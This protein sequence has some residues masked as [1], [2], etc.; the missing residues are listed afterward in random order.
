MRYQ[1]RQVHARIGVGFEPVAEIAH[2][3]AAVLDEQ[4]RVADDDRR[5]VGR[6]VVDLAR[7]LGYR[8]VVWDDREDVLAGIETAD[9]TVSGPIDEALEEERA[10][11]VSTEEQAQMRKLLE[12]AAVQLNSSQK[13]AIVQAEA[14][15]EGF[16]LV[17]G[18]PG[19]GKSWTLHWLLNLIHAREVG[20]MRRQV[21]QLVLSGLKVGGLP[22]HAAHLARMN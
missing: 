8:T 22:P 3:V 21:E 10:A 1:L 2:D 14:D 11:K 5:H 12:S 9:A 17:H 20:S 16:T 13:Q 19:T 7:W 18:P 6:A 15:V 4:D